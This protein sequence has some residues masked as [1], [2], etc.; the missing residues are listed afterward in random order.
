LDD[1]PDLS[2]WPSVIPEIYYDLIARVPAGTLLFLVIASGGQPSLGKLISATSVG[3]AA[4]F[5]TLVLLAGYSSGI[6]ITRLGS[7]F[8]RTYRYRIWRRVLGGERGY[9]GLITTF[10]NQ[11]PTLNL[12]TDDGGRVAVAML[13]AEDVDRLDRVMHDYLK[14]KDPQAKVLLPKMR[15]EAALCDHLFV[16]L[17]G[18]VVVVSCALLW[19]PQEGLADRLGILATF[20]AGST[21]S[22]FCAPYRNERL[23]RRQFSFL[24]LLIPSG[25]Q[26]P[27]SPS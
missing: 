19:S 4:V 2:Q 6:L 16:A 27:S 25:E 24:T 7:L 13:Q 11:F 26:G 8:H 23:I 14:A 5:L 15:A 9:A 1:K 17:I 12:P 10:N 3:S 22:A 18:S 20:L 21:L